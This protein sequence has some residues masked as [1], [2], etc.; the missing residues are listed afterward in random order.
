MAYLLWYRWSFRL[1]QL[2]L[3]ET[4]FGFPQEYSASKPCSLLKNLSPLEKGRTKWYKTG[5]VTSVQEKYDCCLFSL[6]FFYASLAHKPKRGMGW[7]SLLVPGRP[8]LSHAGWNLVS[9]LNKV[10]LQLQFA[11]CSEWFGKMSWAVS[12]ARPWAHFGQV[13]VYNRENVIWC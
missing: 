2:C 1:S 6:L 9:I 10:S 11:S 8:A 4:V 5:Y 12:S 3:L 7:R 13:H